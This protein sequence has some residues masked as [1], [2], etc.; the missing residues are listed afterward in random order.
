MTNPPLWMQEL[1]ERVTDAVTPFDNSTEL[2]CHYYHSE[3]GGEEWEVTLFPDVPQFGG[4]LMG[5]Q[6]KNALSIDIAELVQV[7]SSISNC[8]WQTQVIAD[9]DEV[10]PH[11]SVEG[12]YESNN[13]WLRIASNPP[14][15]LVGMT[16]CDRNTQRVE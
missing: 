4:R 16:Q 7:F 2:A 5:F 12:E 13:V 1:I 11:L 10:G 15:R 8:N 14:T 3:Q 6:E 9:D